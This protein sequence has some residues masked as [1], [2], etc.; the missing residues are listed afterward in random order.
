MYDDDGSHDSGI[1]DDDEVPTSSVT[2]PAQATRTS[3][4]TPE[5]N[6]VGNLTL[7]VRAGF[8]VVF[9]TILCTLAV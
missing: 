6:G 1:V 2:R 7:P 4:T 9:M 5:D 3:G 8:F